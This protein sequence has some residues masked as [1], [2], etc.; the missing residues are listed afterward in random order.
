MRE[1]LL[2]PKGLGGEEEIL[3]FAQNDILVLYSR[4]SEKSERFWEIVLI[5]LNE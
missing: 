4:R 5:T 2:R 3:R 1:R